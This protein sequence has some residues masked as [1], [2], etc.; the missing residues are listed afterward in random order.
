MGRETIEFM[1]GVILVSESP[2]TLADFYTKVLGLPL[3]AEQHDDT[4]PHWGCDLGD[5]HFAIHPAADFP[6]QQSGVGSVKLAFNVW[7][8]EAM[9]ARL[10]EAGQ[11]LLYRPRDTGFFLSTAL[12]DPDGNLVEL[13][14]MSDAWFEYL[15]HR[16]GEGVDVVAK[17][18]SQNRRSDS[19]Q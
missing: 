16:H 10:E 17:W 9:A 5:I 14:Q 8:I 18:K 4:A 12:Q 19:G 1:S 13:T 2:E 7:D 3:Q 15:E 6:D 11:K